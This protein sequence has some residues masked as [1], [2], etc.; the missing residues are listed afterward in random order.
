MV[1]PVRFWARRVEPLAEGGAAAATLA[2]AL[3]LLR[4]ER[5][6]V[7]WRGSLSVP[8]WC[9]GSPGAI[10]GDVRIFAD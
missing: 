7:T 10:S 1:T 5:C 2:D 3:H 4:C 8:C 9:C 6:D